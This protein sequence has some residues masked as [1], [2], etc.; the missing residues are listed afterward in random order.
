MNIKNQLNIDNL[1]NVNKKQIKKLFNINYQ[2]EFLRYRFELLKH[3][4]KSNERYTNKYIHELQYLIDILFLN[5]ELS[6][7]EEEYINHFNGIQFAKERN[8]KNL[9]VDFPK[10]D[11]KEEA[12]YKYTHV[13]FYQLNDNN[14][15]IKIADNGEFYITTQR[16]IYFKNL[17]V[18]SINIDNLKDYKI[19]NRGLMI[20][21]LDTIFYF[22]SYDSY[23][24]YVSLERILKYINKNF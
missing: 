3:W 22:K 10:N 9:I 8:L 13:T 18:Y 14:E 21:T 4:I 17:Q 12:Y 2:E 24:L 7:Y 16:I 1:M 6:C 23:V 20:S 19:T 5:N 11:K 15:I